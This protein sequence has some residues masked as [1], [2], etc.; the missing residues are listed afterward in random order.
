M[1]KEW[2]FSKRKYLLD[3][4]VDGFKTDGGEFVYDDDLI[5]HSTLFGKDMVNQYSKDYIQAY[6]EF[7]GDTRVTFSRAG[8]IGQQSVSIQ[9][10]G[11]QKSTW[12][13]FKSVYNAGIN[14]SLCGQ[15]FWGFDIGGFAGELPSLEL[16][17]RSTQFAVFTPIMQFHSEPVGGQFALIEASKVMNNERSPWNILEQNQRMD[18]MPLFQSLYWMRMNLL[19][20]IY[21]ES[22]QAIQNHTT[23]MKHLMI[24]YSTDALVYKEHNGY[25][26]GNILIVPILEEGVQDT[27]VYFPKG[28]WTHLIT[29]KTYVG[30]TKHNVHTSLYE[31]NA[32]VKD[33]NGIILNLNDKREFPGFVGN[34]ISQ[35]KKLTAF[36][37]GDQGSLN[38]INEES[39]CTINWENK[40]ITV[41]GKCCTEFEFQFK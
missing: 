37:Y 40:E 22:I 34:D 26:L 39:N 38:F 14:A 7:I 18:L 30:G 36:L 4:G 5:F 25:L 11:D 15:T 13:E 29:G 32:F 6:H 20:Y 23:L 17:I 16:Y 33:G 12:K 3:I 27:S 41:S 28:R 2:W 24:D 8:Y 9:W 31:I 10:A 1:M 21:S 35:Y 19:P